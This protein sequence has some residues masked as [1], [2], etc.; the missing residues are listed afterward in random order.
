MAD[1]SVDLYNAS[2]NK[3]ASE[4]QRAVRAE[5]YGEDIGQSG[6]MTANELRRFI[7]FLDLKQTDRVLEIG[8]GSGGPA[9]FL[10]ETVGCRLIGLDTNEFGVKNSIDLARQRGLE[11]KAQF[12]LA[13]ASQPLEFELETF[14]AIISNDAM[15]HISGRLQAL[16]EWRRVLKP[17]G[18]ML[19]TDAL[20]ITGV[21]SHEEIARRSSIGLYFFVPEGENERLIR[22][23]GFE[24]IRADDLTHDAAN[25]AKRWHDARAKHRAEMIRIEGEMNFD[26]LQDFL[27][28]VRMLCNE[29]RLSRF[30]YLG[31]KPV[32]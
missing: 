5:T 25:I 13:D 23:A 8:S 18:Q 9:L 26:G 4:A 3:F 22:E 20:V 21:V 7:A 19:F 28:C 29:G 12:R 15:C 11:S 30:A 17:G 6:W 16:K 27:A 10:A 24:L 1:A 32:K 14:D 31:Q 2:Y